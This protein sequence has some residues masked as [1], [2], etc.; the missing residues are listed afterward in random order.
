MK[1]TKLIIT[2]ILLILITGCNRN[3]NNNNN[4]KEPAKGTD[5]KTTETPIPSPTPEPLPLSGLKICIDAG[6]QQF[7]NN[8]LE[9]MAPWSDEKKMK[10]AGGAPGE[11]IVD[12]SI[13]LKIRDTLRALGADVLMIRE[14]NDVN[15]SN[16]ERAETANKYGADLTL[17]IHCNGNDNTD[18]NGIEIYMRDKGDNSDKHN[19][20]AA[21]EYQFASELMRSLVESTGAANRSVRKSDLYTGINWSDV[22]CLIIE[23]GYLSNA[24]EGEKLKS[25]EYQAKIAEGIAD[26]LLKTSLFKND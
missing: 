23:C 11:Y 6:H 13:S 2:V 26:C 3:I 20:L 8:E 15:I 4:T 5:A 24:A 21:V 17:R 12:L 22:P 10:V 18:I 19:K 16:K 9:A 14:T 1:G 7:S 25:D